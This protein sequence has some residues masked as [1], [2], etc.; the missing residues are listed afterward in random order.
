MCQETGGGGGGQNWHLTSRAS[1]TLIFF[2]IR[3]NLINFFFY[4]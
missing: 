3:S 2:G 4:K 1:Q